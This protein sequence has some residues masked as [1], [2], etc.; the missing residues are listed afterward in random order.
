MILR[1][2]GAARLPAFRSCAAASSLRLFVPK[3]GC[4]P[5]FLWNFIKASSVCTSA[6][7]LS[8]DEALRPLNCRGASKDARLNPTAL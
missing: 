1:R 3:A 8:G 7:L 4:L 5:F 6:A 2:R